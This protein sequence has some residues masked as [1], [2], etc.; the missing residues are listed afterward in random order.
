LEVS[1]FIDYFVNH[2]VSP[3]RF[4]EE[5]AAMSSAGIDTCIEFGPGKTASTLAKKNNRALATMNV[6]T[7]ETLEKTVAALSATG[8]VTT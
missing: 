8:A 7:A 2:M 3:V 6:D 4:V 1:D 5:I